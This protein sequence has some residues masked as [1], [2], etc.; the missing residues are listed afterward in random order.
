MASATPEASKLTSSAEIFSANHT[1][2]QIRSI[3]K[4]LHVQIEEKSS[5]LRTQVGDSYRELLGTAE[6]IVH[7]RGDNDSVQD[8]L[9]KMG[10]RCGRTIISTKAS[11]LSGFVSREPTSNV[12]ETAKLKLLEACLHIV[13]RVLKG[14]GGLAEDVKRGD[15]LVLATKVF[16]ISRLLVK[17]MKGNASIGDQ[18]RQ[19]MEAASKSLE[20]LRRRIQRSVERILEKADESTDIEDVVKA[21]CAQSLANSSGAKHAIG[22]FIRVRQRGMEIALDLDE[23]ERTTTTDDAVRSLRLYT[24][25]LIDVQALVPNRLSQALAALKSQPLLADV[26]LKKLEELRLDVYK[27][28]CSEEIK[29]FTPFI[30]HDDLD[31][32]QAREMLGTFAENG[33]QIVL[34]GLKKTLDHMGDFKSII[35][36]R[37][38]LLQLWIRD[39]GKAKGFDPQ[40]MQD[41]IRDAINSRLLSVLE[42]KV[43]K[44]R[45]VGSEVKATFEGWQDGVTDKHAN[46][47]DDDGYA[48]ALS[49][50]AAPFIQEVVS[51]LYGRNDA[52]SKASHSYG[53]WF[54]IIDDVKTVVEQLKKQRWDNDYD[55]IEDEETID[56][57]QK[58]LSKEDPKKLQQKLDTTLDKSFRD[59][60]TQF[61]DLWKEHSKNTTSGTMAI[62][63]V[64]VLRD[65][66]A[67]LP[68]R[69]GIKDFGLSMVPSLHEQMALKISKP[70]ADVFVADGLS[71]RSVPT[72][73]L[74]EG[75]PPLPSQPSPALF[76][77][78]QKLCLSMIDAGVDLWT[79][80]AATVLKLHLCKQLCEAW[81]NELGRIEAPQQTTNGEKEE[82]GQENSKE[83]SKKGKRGKTGKKGTAN[84]KNEKDNDNTDQKDGKEN[85]DDSKKEKNNGAEHDNE[86]GKDEN[87]DES[88]VSAVDTAKD[89]CTQWQFDI[90]V[91][92]LSVG[93]VS[94]EGSESLSKL[95]DEIFKRT[96]LEDGSKK[97]VKK[98]AQDFWQ[99]VSLLFGLLA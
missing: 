94:G 67:Q 54:H 75:E 41:D 2:P 81:Q 20:S 62:Y 93:R 15:R 53:S 29:E 23:S 37:T 74:W 25:T 97:R 80:A 63:L 90:A 66:R 4:S 71:D 73:P 59:L 31:S 86:A 88:P 3:H 51:R 18:A 49:N 38:K 96:E 44:L 10:G 52:V 30:R 87:P 65:I 46:L 47:W 43:T 50:G 22:H 6:T 77:F 36:M 64:R 95:E 45:L 69:P 58:I 57:R 76:Q 27:R 26:S 83:G 99:R 17:S 82:K 24:K 85:G 28:W 48:S 84:L 42:T 35:D 68:D 5:R 14:G 78:L 72:R 92:R 16:V 89:V 8:L 61:N 55:E 70:A 13:G 91:L 9:G 1:L 11:Q 40:E 98:S 34:S 39:G 19:S 33:G 79:P 32:K 7:M 60:E 12:G 56:A 21:L